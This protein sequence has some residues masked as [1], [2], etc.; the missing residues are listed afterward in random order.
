MRYACLS[1]KVN[2]L[3]ALKAR[4]SHENLF[5]GWT[6]KMHPECASHVLYCFIT[7]ETKCLDD[8][9]CIE[10]LSTAS[11]FH[12]RYATDLLQISYRS[13]LCQVSGR[14][15]KTV[16]RSR[17]SLHR[18]CSASPGHHSWVTWHRHRLKR[19]AF[20]AARGPRR[21]RTDTKH[22]LFVWDL[23]PRKVLGCKLRPA[24]LRTSHG[25]SSYIKWIQVIS[26]QNA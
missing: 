10:V 20:G 24:S 25:I 9:W 19:K 8:S 18:C 11:Q 15:I 14:S 22:I 13:L 23:L 3:M 1:G 12:Y 17:C 4:D 6:Q 26:R 7:M 21:V 16:H 2:V 5:D